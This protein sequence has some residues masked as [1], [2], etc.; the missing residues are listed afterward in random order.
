[1]GGDAAVLLGLD[2]GVVVA[3]VLVG[4][5]LGELGEGLVEGVAA[6]EVGGDG[7]AVAGAGVGPG[8]GPAAEAAVVRP[9]SAGFM[10]STTAEPFQ[11]RSW[12]T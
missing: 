9:W 3:F 1:M 7:D 4:V 6:A 5:G 8:Q 11:S 12:R 10:V 2:E